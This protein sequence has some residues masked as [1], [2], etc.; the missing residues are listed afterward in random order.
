M[1]CC[2][3]RR[4]FHKLLSRSPNEVL[5]PMVRIRP[6]VEGDRAAILEIT[7][8]V[9]REVG[10]D[11]LIEQVFGTLGGTTWQ[12]RKVAQVD[13]ELA[14]VPEGILVAEAEGSVVGYVTTMTNPATRLGQISNIAVA[15][16]WQGRG[17]GRRLLLAALD[18]L[19]SAGMTHA[20][21]ETLEN[22]EAGKHLYLSVGFVEIVRQIHYVM[23]L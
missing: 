10:V 12:Q 15:A 23:R 14:V 21:I 18:R 13:S 11:H 3:R 19:R 5:S 6:F 22:N 20:K 9:F 4:G 16:Q 8:A 1:L 2:Q 7:A 17:V